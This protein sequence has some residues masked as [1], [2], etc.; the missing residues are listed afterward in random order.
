[1]TWQGFVLLRVS[2]P[3]QLPNFDRPVPAAVSVTGVPFANWPRHALEQIRPG[4][5]L[6]TV[7]DPLPAKVRVRISVDAPPPPV[8]VKQTTL[9]VMNPVTTAPDDDKPPVLL[10][11]VT[12][13]ETSVPPHASPVAVSMP[14]ELTLNI[15]TSFEAHVTRFVMSLVTGGWM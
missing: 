14:V 3:N 2:Q 10:L 12:V 8:L 5:E 4:G 9:A 1:M 13:A 6:V 7:P 15:C 11:V